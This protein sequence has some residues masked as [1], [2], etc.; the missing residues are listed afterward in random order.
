M[1]EFSMMSIK[2]WKLLMRKKSGLYDWGKSC[3]KMKQ[4]PLMAVACT[5]ML[6]IFYRTTSYQ[7]HETEQFQVD[8]SQSIWEGEE[9]IPEYSGKLRGLPHGIIHATSDFELKPLWSR[10]SSSSKVP[11]Y[12]NRNLL[13]VPVGMR[14]KDNVNNMVQKFLQD[15]FT[16]MLF[17]Y[18]GNVDGWRDHDWS[19][20]AIHI[21]AQNQTKWWF[22]KRFLHPDIV[23]IYDYIFLWDEDLGVEHF[24]PSRYIEIVKQEGLEISQPALAPDSI[25]IHHRI[26]LRARNKKFH[27]RIYERRGKTRCSGASQGPP[28]AGFVEG[29]APVFSKSAWYCA[30]HLIQGDRTRKVGV[31]DEEYIV[32]KGIQTLGGGGQAS[33]KI[34][35]PKLAKRHRAAAGDVRIQIRR[36]STQELE[37]FKKRWYE[38]VAEDKNWVDPYAR[39]KR[40]V[41]HQVSHERFS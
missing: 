14:Q 18:D 37:V 15:N 30:W 38:E 27:R 16:V 12:S 20:K 7:Y 10:R 39:Q 31:V 36:Q 41:R 23:Y 40:L 24:S 9:G 13:A 25:E 29:M 4:L 28:C 22:A 33:T 5:V 11:V 34:S 8:Q 6:F 1:I 35:N 21:V 19:S 2:S 3:L 17:H 32:H 26:T